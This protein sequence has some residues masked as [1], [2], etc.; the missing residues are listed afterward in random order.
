MVPLGHADDR[1]G[2]IASLVGQHESGNAGDVGLECQDQEVAQDAHVLLE[3]RGDAGRLRHVGAR[4][5]GQL[6]GALD[7]LLDVAD[8]GEVF[9]EPQ[10][11]V[12]REVRL[13]A[14]RLVHDEVEHALPI[15]I[16]AN[17]VGVGAT[18]EQPFKNEP[19]VVDLGD[20]RG[21]R[22]PGNRRRVD[23]AITRVAVAG[24][25]A[26]IAA[27]LQRGEPGL[28]ADTGGGCLIDRDAGADVSAVGLARLATGQEG[29]H[30][31]PVIAGAIAVGP[32]LVGSQTG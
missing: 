2:T 31:P 27:D 21:G 14:A 29:G 30:G 3:I 7:A 6:S 10:V 25:G 24:H 20:R 8:R 15:A 23:A 9:I 13:E 16:T 22:P 19:R 18:A 1:V 26:R 32:S 11:V 17:A 5:L 4:R 12:A 28:M